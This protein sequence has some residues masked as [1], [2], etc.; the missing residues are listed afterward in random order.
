MKAEPQRCRRRRIDFEFPKILPTRAYTIGTRR[1]PRT[2]CAVFEWTVTGML[3]VRDARNFNVAETLLQS[4]MKISNVGGRR[5][6]FA[7][8]FLE[9]TDAD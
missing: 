7:M 3:I 4:G 5:Y 6:G 8:Q 1:G 9:G 2:L